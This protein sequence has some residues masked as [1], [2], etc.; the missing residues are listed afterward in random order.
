MATNANATD[1]IELDRPKD[2]VN[3][4]YHGLIWRDLGPDHLAIEFFNSAVNWGD[5]KLQTLSA[6]PE[7]GLLTKNYNRGSDNPLNNLLAAPVNKA[8]LA[9]DQYFKQLIALQDNY[10]NNL[11]YDLV[12]GLYS[13]GY[14]SNS[15]VAGLV[16]VSGGFTLLDFNLYVGGA[17]PVPAGEFR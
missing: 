9:P 2:V 8:D 4:T 16:Q 10:K 12:P 7:N 1:E 17:K 3:I 14:N 6:G 15:Y 5:K 11:N 13:D